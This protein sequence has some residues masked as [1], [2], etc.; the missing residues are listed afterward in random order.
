MH[1]C[2]AN[3]LISNMLNFWLLPNWSTVHWRHPQTIAKIFTPAIWNLGWPVICWKN[4]L[5]YV[6]TS[7]SR[8]VTI[9]SGWQCCLI[10]RKDQWSRLVELAVHSLISDILVSMM[11]AHSMTDIS[12]MLGLQLLPVI[13]ESK[14]KPKN[15]LVTS[16]GTRTEKML[17][18]PKSPM[19]L[20]YFQIP[21][22]SE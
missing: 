7:S 2:L 6:A 16:T 9:S 11:I 18:F 22:H 17:C 13:I 12:I 1:L 15:D 8:P 5:Y 4:W 14:L 21:T 19:L 3:W 20:S 10:S